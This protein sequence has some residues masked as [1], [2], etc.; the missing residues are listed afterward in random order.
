M[1]CVYCHHVGVYVYVHLCA[2]V[3]SCVHVYHMGC[4]AMC[5]Y[6]IYVYVCMLC[7]EI[8]TMHTY[9]LILW[10]IL[11]HNVLSLHVQDS[12]MHVQWN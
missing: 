9:T 6:R 3:H 8:K 1:V 5:V 2:Y 4:V 12:S 11:D 10:F 7:S